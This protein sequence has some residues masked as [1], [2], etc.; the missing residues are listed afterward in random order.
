[1][2]SD[3]PHKSEKDY[4]HRSS[5]ES[6][7]EYEHADHAEHA[8]DNSRLTKT[9]TDEQYHR[10]REASQKMANPL[11]GLG[12]E[13]LAAMG[14]KYCHEHGFT[15]EEDIRAFRLG[16]M[17]AG[18]ENKFDTIKDLTDDERRVLGDEI[19]HKW[20]NPATM[21]G[22]IIGMSQQ[23]Y[24]SVFGRAPSSVTL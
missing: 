21:Y 7:T 2:S 18:N 3:L 5:S 12:P 13:R 19:T 10:Q 24:I 4:H 16:A 22:V 20:K 23:L 6:G 8:G 9:G 11:A 14:E 17:I 1:M 15:S